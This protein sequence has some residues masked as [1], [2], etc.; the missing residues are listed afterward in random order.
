MVKH[1]NK[2]FFCVLLACL[3]VLALASGERPDVLVQRISDEVLEIVRNDTQLRAG[4]TDEAIRLVEEV[5]LPH[6]NFRR[7]TMLA[8]GR[9]WRDASPDQQQKLMDAFYNLLVRTYS[10]ALTQYRDQTIHF[11]PFRMNEGDRT[12]RVLSEIRQSGAQPIEVDYTLE[13]G[14]DGWKVFD[15]AVAGVSLV[16]N[17]RSTFAQEIRSG[18]IDG[19]IRSLESR[20]EQA[21]TQAEAS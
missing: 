9:D 5:V 17:Y 4:N 21:R 8:V 18:G 6:F 16:T 10:N 13:L 19:L 7:M 14:S 20:A 11:K 12:V 2:W 1:L 3:P 15:I